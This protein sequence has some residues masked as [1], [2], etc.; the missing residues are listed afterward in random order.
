L[1][2][3]VGAEESPGLAYPLLVGLGSILAV[4]LVVLLTLTPLIQTDFWIQAKVGELIW[5]E[6]SIPRTGLF[7]YTNARDFPFVAY[8]W[9]PSVLFHLL[10]DRFGYEGAIVVK[11]VLG[12][13]IFA[14]VFRLAYRINRHAVL[15]A[16]IAV[17]TLLT[18]NYRHFLRPELFGHVCLL[19][20]LNA[21]FEYRRTG[22]FGWLLAVIPISVLWTNAHG[23][24]LLGIALLPLFATGDLFDAAMRGVLGRERPAW[25][26]ALRRSAPYVGVFA[27]VACAVP[28]NPHGFDLPRHSLALSSADYIRNLVPEWLPTFEAQTPPWVHRTYLIHL[29]VLAAFLA[30]GFR[31]LRGWAVLLTAFFGYLSQ[32][33]LRHI[34][35][36]ALAVS[37]VLAQLSRHLCASPSCKRLLAGVLAA[38]LALT[39][40]VVRERGN[41]LGLRTGFERAAPLS[42]GALAYIREHGFEGNAFCSYDL[43]DQLIFHFY[44]E[45][46]VNVDSRVDVFGGAY[47]RD[48]TLAL[49]R[50]PRLERHLARYDV[51]YLILTRR[52]YASHV[53]KMRAALDAAQWRLVYGDRRT[54]IFERD[55]A[56]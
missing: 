32:D 53:S 55:P 45:L 3:A 30:L 19:L 44:P 6:R 27:M 40:G 48:Y 46:R 11:G 35:V 2:R 18:A 49:T 5:N 38:A 43:G 36:Y 51:R 52:D 14:L 7:H 12:V 13:A 29:A 15:A 34:A 31:K 10:Y 50:W 21:I 47:M 42:E 54:V 37:P 41:V 4:V 25:R 39:I 28:M 9:G 56:G 23:S 17:L 20:E 8:E 26:D 16:F 33:A 22:R 1:R 24:Y